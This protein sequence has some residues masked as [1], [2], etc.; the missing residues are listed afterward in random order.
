MIFDIH[1]QLVKI[2]VVRIQDGPDSTQMHADTRTV[3]LSRNES[4]PDGQVQLSEK[5]IL[6]PESGMSE[7]IVHQTAPIVVL[8]AALAMYINSDL[9]GE[10]ALMRGPKMVI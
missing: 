4:S 5:R 10:F 6:F 2:L 1:P 8:A 9:S 7:K 3:R